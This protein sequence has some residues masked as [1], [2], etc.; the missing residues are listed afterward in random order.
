MLRMSYSDHFL[1]VV[2]P[3]VRADAKYIPRLAFVLMFG[4]F[5]HCV[6][7]ICFVWLQTGVVGLKKAQRDNL[8][9][10]VL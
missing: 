7:K 1:S 5:R 9:T 3:S 8:T 4:L 2:R 10:S 6:V